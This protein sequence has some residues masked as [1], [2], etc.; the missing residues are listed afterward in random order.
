MWFIASHSMSMMKE[1]FTPFS[2]SSDKDAKPQLSNEPK[3]GDSE[4]ERPPIKQIVEIPPISDDPEQIDM[5]EILKSIQFH[6]IPAALL[7]GSKLKSAG[8]GRN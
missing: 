5:R 6:S 2:F 4:D 3:S 1:H 7:F 8:K